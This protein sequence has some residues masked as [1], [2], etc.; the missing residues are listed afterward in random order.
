MDYQGRCT[1][2]Y[3][4]KE[5]FNLEIIYFVSAF[6]KGI[7]NILVILIYLLTLLSIS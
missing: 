5:S 2:F 6:E 3:P 7:N 1:I 4:T